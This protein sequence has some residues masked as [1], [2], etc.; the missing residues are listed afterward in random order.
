[1]IGLGGASLI[2]LAS[3]VEAR[4]RVLGISI[5]AL[6]VIGG[7]MLAR[8]MS[9]PYKRLVDYEH[10]GFARWFWKENA[11]EGEVVCLH[12][13]LG[14]NFYASRTF[15]RLSLLSAQR[16]RRRTA[17]AGGTSKCQI[18]P[19]NCRPSGHCAA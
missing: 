3:R 14:R 7:V 6:F 11:E 16:I 13:D 17:A 4:H 10:R 9:H 18:C 15:R 12:T 8:D 19:R 5:A 1:M 2:G